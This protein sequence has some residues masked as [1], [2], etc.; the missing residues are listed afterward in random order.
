MKDRP[1]QLIGAAFVAACR[2]LTPAVGAADRAGGD[3]PGIDAEKFFSALVKVRAHALDCRS[4]PG[5]SRRRSGTHAAGAGCWLRSFE[6]AGIGPADI[7]LAVGD[8]AVRSQA[9]FYHKIWGRGAAGS[10][11]PLRLLQDMDVHDIN[12]HSI[13]RIGYFRQKTSY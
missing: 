13:D 10:D 8:E 1:R 2:V 12:V 5:R 9:E 6:R 4:G 7:I 11:I 3:A